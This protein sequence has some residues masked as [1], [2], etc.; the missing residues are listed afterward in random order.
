MFTDA[1]SLGADVD[2]NKV[3]FPEA[4]KMTAPRNGNVE[5]RADLDAACI[6]GTGYLIGK[7]FNITDL[8]GEKGKKGICLSTG[9]AV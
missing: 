7:S 4:A 5:G 3:E 9:A 2:R 8:T 6:A 1:G